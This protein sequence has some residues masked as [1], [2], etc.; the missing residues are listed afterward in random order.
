MNSFIWII[1]FSSAIKIIKSTTIES[2]IKY[3][4]ATGNWGIKSTNSKVGIAQVL[5][6]LTYNATLSHL[7]RINTPT[8]KTGKLVPPRKLHNTQW[9]IV[10]PSETPEGGSVGLVKN[11]GIMTYITN[12]SSDEPIIK[13]IDEGIGISKNAQKQIFNKFYREQKGNIHDVKGHG[14]GLAY[15]KEILDSHH[16]TVFVESEKGKGSTFTIKLPLI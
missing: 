8:E 2:G 12:Q 3:G 15:V 5:N 6:R 11:I 14:L 13:I 9:G 16:G 10:C 1:H 7:R 4:L